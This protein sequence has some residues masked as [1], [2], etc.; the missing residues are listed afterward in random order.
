MSDILHDVHT[1]EV[2][3]S[4]IMEKQNKITLKNRELK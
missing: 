2:E 4:E 3:I 1:N